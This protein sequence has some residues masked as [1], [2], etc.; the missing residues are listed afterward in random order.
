MAYHQYASWNRKIWLG[1]SESQCQRKNHGC[2]SSQVPG[3]PT[4]PSS[5]NGPSCWSPSYYHAPR[6]YGISRRSERKK[7][8]WIIQK[9]NKYKNNPW[10][11]TQ[12]I[13]FWTPYGWMG[14]FFRV[15]FGGGVGSSFRMFLPLSDR[16]GESITSWLVLTRYDFTPIKTEWVLVYLTWY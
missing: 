1:C 4:P 12:S 14:S 2:V 6:E 13:F 15:G 5:S 11:T 9:T 16:R 8:T 7:L 3:R 10:A